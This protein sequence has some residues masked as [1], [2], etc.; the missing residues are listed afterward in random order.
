MTTQTS[1]LS[2]SLSWIPRLALWL[3]LIIVLLLAVGYIYQR[4]T[5]AADFEQVPPPGQRVDVGGYSLHIYCTGEGS[6]PTI[7][8]D[9]GNGD[10]SVTWT[11]IQRE[12][13]KSAR[14]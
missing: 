12:V 3:T 13:E 4:R 7:V 9:A 1:A 10:F 14:I 6:G 2:K 11:G 8:V 5:T